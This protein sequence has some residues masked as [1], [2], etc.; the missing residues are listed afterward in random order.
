MEGV[1][2]WT[3]KGRVKTARL[4][5]KDKIRFVP[6]DKYHP[7]NPLPRDKENINPKAIP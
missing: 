5:T 3:V 2:P 7:S 1:K 4:P 6:K